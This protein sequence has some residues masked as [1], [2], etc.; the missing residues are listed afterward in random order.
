MAQ[1]EP[2]YDAKKEEGRE[3]PSSFA[4]FVIVAK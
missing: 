4:E 3:R 1:L 2:D